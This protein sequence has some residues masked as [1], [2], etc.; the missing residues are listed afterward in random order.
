MVARITALMRWSCPA[1]SLSRPIRAEAA[2][3]VNMAPSIL[4]EFGLPTPS[5]MEGRDVFSS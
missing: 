4:A 3:L 2:R 1:C 5:S